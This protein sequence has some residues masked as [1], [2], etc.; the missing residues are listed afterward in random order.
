MT[1]SASNSRS[2][3]ANYGIYTLSVSWSESNPTVAANKSRITASASLSSNDTAFA[4][5]YVQHISVYWFDN[6]RYPN[7]VKL[8]GTDFYECGFEG[9]GTKSASGSI[10]VEHKDDGTLSGYCVTYFTNNNAGP[11]APDSASCSTSSKALDTIARAS[12][13]TVSPNPLV[14]S[15]V[16]NPLTVATNRK[17]TLFTH[18]ITCEAGSFT[19][20]QTGVTDSCTFNIPQTILADFPATSQTLEGTITCVTKNGSTTIGT[21][22]AQ[23]TAQI[24]TAAEHPVIDA[25]TITDLNP[26]SAAIEAAGSLIKNASKLRATIPV[27]VAGSYTQ[28]D[29]A[30]VVCGNVSRTYSLSGTSGT[31]TFDYDLI[32]VDSLT[33]YLTDERGTTV[34]QTK[35]WTLIPYTNLT[36]T[37]TIDRTSE[38]GDT[39][40]F[41]LKGGCFAG[42]FGNATNQITVSYKWKLRSASTY[43][44]GAVT[45]T[46]TPTGSGETSFEYSNQITGFDYDKQYDIIF[47]VED[48]FTSADTRELNLTTGI[49]VW[50]NGSD[51]FAVYGKSF[52]HYDRDNPSKF[53][54]IDGALNGILEHN[55]VKNLLQVT[56]TTET[57]NGVTFTPQADGSVKVSGTA[58]AYTVYTLG[59]FTTKA[60]LDYILSGCPAGGSAFTYDLGIG[61]L[62]TDKGGGFT[63]S[64]DGSTYAVTI[65]VFNGVTV[66]DIVF[67]PMIRDARIASES[68]V[69]GALPMIP[70]YLQ[71]NLSLPANVGGGGRVNEDF[72]VSGSG[73]IIMFASLMDNA[74]G[75]YG[76]MRVGFD[77]KHAEDAWFALAETLD[78]NISQGSGQ[79]SARVCSSTAVIAANG[80]KLQLFYAVSNDGT[81][82]ILRSQFVSFGCI[83]TKD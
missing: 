68:Y 9:Y 64:G 45:F 52:L 15:A 1:A 29:N 22:T 36:V 67:T 3:S 61:N 80:D 79:Y 71:Y 70:N 58:T 19:E 54:D 47:T 55:G 56:G 74:N 59:T 34:S 35:S 72:T 43:T 39:V 53:W 7:G 37:G 76:T 32:D 2:L 50:G 5:N 26:N 10:E 60:G 62:G 38:T 66:D 14:L 27:S 4:S 17:S 23:F 12:V 69:K 6:N 24:N 73:L 63:F 8:G 28:L 20:T 49:P 77:Y 25:I 46:F 30:V 78:R 83:V 81:T 41:T 21:K 51:F 18:E 11:Y 75:N 44:P 48:L 33:V 16:S 57:I 31:I 82:H 13:P 40:A 65:G 42:S